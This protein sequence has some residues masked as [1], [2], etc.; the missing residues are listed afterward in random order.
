M[1]HKS[2]Y[3]SENER[4]ALRQQSSCLSQK[5]IRPNV[6]A[7]VTGSLR[8]HASEIVC[9]I[10]W[11]SARSE[12]TVKAVTGSEP[13]GKVSCNSI[14]V[15]ISPNDKNGG[16]PQSTV[17]ILAPLPLTASECETLSMPW[18]SVFAGMRGNV[19][20]QAAPSGCEYSVAG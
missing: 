19:R 15:L 13:S 12:E 2:F 11:C 9:H 18:R 3:Q 6:A 4:T 1:C 10:T 16:D 8:A 5:N 7:K 17:P 20:N 14:Q